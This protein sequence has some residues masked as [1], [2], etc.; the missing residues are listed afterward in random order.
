MVTYVFCLTKVISKKDEEDFE[1]KPIL[2][3]LCTLYGTLFIYSLSNK[4]NYIY[5][6]S[7]KKIFSFIISF[8][9][10]SSSFIHFCSKK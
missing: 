3:I 8:K 1:F 10:H 6:L 9:I 2:H 7:S 5:S 4:I